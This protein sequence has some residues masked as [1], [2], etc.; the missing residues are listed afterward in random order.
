MTNIS[1][2]C[3]FSERR[4]NFS[5][6]GRYWSSNQFFVLLGQLA[7]DNNMAIPGSFQKLIERFA[8]PVGR[9]EEDN[10]SSDGSGTVKP[11]HSGFRPSRWEPQE[12]EG[13]ARQSRHR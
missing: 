11:L 8:N 7:T 2:H 5:K 1:H 12:R 3:K 4:A 13:L 9:F 6:N 10:R